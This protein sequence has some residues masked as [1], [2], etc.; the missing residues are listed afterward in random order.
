METDSPTLE[1]FFM[2]LDF[3][4]EELELSK[5]GATTRH[6]EKPIRIQSNT[7]L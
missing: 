4:C 3:P 1:E 6:P 5:K 2:F 7:K